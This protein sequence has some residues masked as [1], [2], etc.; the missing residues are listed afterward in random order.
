MAVVASRAAKLADLP[1]ARITATRQVNELGGRRGKPLVLVIRETV[2]DGYIF[3]IE[4]P[5]LA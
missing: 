2:L 5:M 3:S 1:D 4:L